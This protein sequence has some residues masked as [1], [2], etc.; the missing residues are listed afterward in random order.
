MRVRVYIAADP[1]PIGLYQQ[2][3]PARHIQQ[4]PAAIGQRKPGTLVI[5]GSEPEPVGGL[6]AE[7][8]VDGKERVV[9][10]TTH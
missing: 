9:G 1:V 6:L 10:Q 4:F 7:P 2:V 5:D 3:V 8:H